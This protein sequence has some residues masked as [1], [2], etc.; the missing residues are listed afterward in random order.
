MVT[1][2][3]I[4]EFRNC[5]DC[6]YRGKCCYKGYLENKGITPGTYVYCPVARY[7]R[8]GVLRWVISMLIG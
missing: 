6:V 7:E 2:V 1:G 3:I 8:K 4:V 5:F